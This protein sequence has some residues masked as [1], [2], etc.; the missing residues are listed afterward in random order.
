[1]YGFICSFGQAPEDFEAQTLVNLIN[2]PALMT[3]GWNPADPNAMAISADGLTLDLENTGL[4]HHVGRAGTIMDLTTL[5]QSPYICTK[6]TGRGLFSIAQDGTR[7]LHFYFDNFMTDLENR[8]SNN[9]AVKFVLAKGPFND[10]TA[11]LTAGWIVIN[12]E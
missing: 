3:V 10:E 11:T 8:L 7:Q 5:S 4:F 1:M 2:I 12:L 9:K 6:P